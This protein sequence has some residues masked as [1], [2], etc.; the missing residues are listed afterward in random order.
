MW[1]RVS[2]LVLLSCVVLLS[3]PPAPKAQMPPV[4]DLTGRVGLGLLL[5]QLATTGVLMQATAHPDDENNG[6]LAALGWGAGRPHR[7]RDGD[8]RRRRPERDRPGAVQR[9]GRAAH[10]RAARGAPHGQRRAVLP[11]RRRLRVLV[12]HGRDVR[13]MGPPGD[14]RRL[15]ADD[16]HD[17][18]GRHRRDA[19]GRRG[20]RPASPG[21]G[22][23][24][25]RGVPR[26]RRRG[27]SS[28]NSCATA[29][30]RGSRRSSTSRCATDFPASRRLRQA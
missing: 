2:A 23:P 28:P 9:A 24:R 21:F 25:A 29:C 16:P 27:E 3:T 20:R 6:M 10:G 17:P 22:D 5:R 7:R 26:R 1:R 11:P 13:E 18:A 4:S 15:R 30:G 12:Q 14:P 19:P 8:A